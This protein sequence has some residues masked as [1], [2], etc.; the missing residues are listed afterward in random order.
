MPEKPIS[1]EAEPIEKDDRERTFSLMTTEDINAEKALVTLE[2]NIELFKRIRILSLKLTK[3]SDWVD[4]NGTP[5]LMDKGAENIAIAYG[6][7]ISGTEV[8][9]EWRGDG[10]KRYYAYRV[11]AKGYSRRLGRYVEDIG[12]SSQHDKFFG[13]DSVNKKF[14]PVEEVDED[15]IIKKAVTNCYGRI[16]KRITALLSVTFDDLKESGMEISKITR[17]E[18]KT[19]AKKTEAAAPVSTEAK[20]KRAEIWRMCIALASGDNATALKILDEAANFPGYKGPPI[21]DVSRI[22]SER[23]I[24]STYDKLQKRMDAEFQGPEHEGEKK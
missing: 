9:K 16:I 19:G 6:I 8:T 18:Y 2:K 10:D 21:N 24:N 20:D 15:M 23:W 22:S 14:K 1:D 11:T 12:T 4:Q 7:D 17:I 5:Y 3:P 13:Y